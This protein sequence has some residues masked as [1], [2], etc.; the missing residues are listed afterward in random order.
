MLVFIFFL[1]HDSVSVR[2]KPNQA[3]FIF[4]GNIVKTALLQQLIQNL[5]KVTHGSASL[6]NVLTTTHHHPIP[7]TPIYKHRIRGLCPEP[8]GAT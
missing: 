7:T 8:T 3:P 6:R 2:N 5:R 4:L 1:W